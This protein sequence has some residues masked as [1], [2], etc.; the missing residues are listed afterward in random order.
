MEAVHAVALGACPDIQ[1]GGQH[2]EVGVA[3]RG[4]HLGPSFSFPC[5]VVVIAFCF[6]HVGAKLMTRWS[7]DELV[8]VVSEGVVG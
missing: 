8:R 5:C 4:T 3:S 6:R 2:C 1:L 7:C